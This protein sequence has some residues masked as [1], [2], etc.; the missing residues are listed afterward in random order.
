MASVSALYNHP[1]KSLTPQ[2]VDA[3]RLTDDG[4]VGGDRV[5]GFRFRDAGDPAD[6][7]WQTKNN[8]VGLIN[9]P[10]LARLAAEF[11]SETKILKIHADDLCIVEGEIDDPDSR[12]QIERSF[13]DFVLDLDENPLSDHP[14]RCPVTLVGDGSQPL[15][16]DTAAGL[17]TLHSE[18]SLEALASSLDTPELD[19]RR[20][21]S[22]IVVSGLNEPFE[23][24]SWVGGRVA[25]GETEFKVIKPV[26]R[27]LVTHANPVTGK[28]D[29]DIMNSLVHKFTPEK[30]QFA[31]TLQT[32][33]SERTVSVGD[34]LKLID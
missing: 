32:I 6:W 11:N 28:R 8:F 3:I 19:G 23:E 27:C 2:R 30:P 18:T 29:K 4:R 26:N 7:S 12:A 14:E 24:M 10:G 16:H 13:T 33:S 31:V 15:F 17:V 21:R 9:T 22:N 20:F 1:V 34:E 5:L 25:I